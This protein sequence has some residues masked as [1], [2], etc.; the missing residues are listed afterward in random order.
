MTRAASN[1]ELW[2]HR[3]LT[4]R[5]RSRPGWVHEVCPCVG[6]F[7]IVAMPSVASQPGITSRESAWR[8]QYA[9]ARSRSSGLRPRDVQVATSDERSGSHL[10]RV[11]NHGRPRHGVK[12][13][14]AGP[15]SEGLLMTSIRT[16]NDSRAE[17]GTPAT[18]MPTTSLRGEGMRSPRPLD[19]L[20]QGIRRGDKE[21]LDVLFTMVYQRLR[22]AA[23]RQLQAQVPGGTL[24]TTA[25]V[26]ETYV[27][28]ARTAGIHASDR[29]HFFRVAAKAMRQILVDR[30]R[31]NLTQKR[32]GS[33]VA[34]DAD[35]A[36]LTIGARAAEVLAL[37]EA[38]SALANLDARLARV[39]EL[40]FFAGLSVEETGAA[41]DIGSR[42]VKRD[43]Q[44]ARM[45]LNRAISGSGEGG[46]S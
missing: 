39:V 35:L 30:A 22:T 4:G 31:A 44:K 21:A 9:G 40:R 29:K 11:A 28:L 16:Q 7:M 33:W 10:N 1:G 6:G 43:W 3:M 13:A 42:T 18:E 38:L 26:H 36:G 24:N 15:P 23:H 17:E 20:I 37:D 2:E 12:G 45:Y 46:G 8:N 32:G 34:V 41:L 14:A 25:L 19:R 27:K 5:Y